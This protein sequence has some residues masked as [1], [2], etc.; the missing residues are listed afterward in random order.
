[1]LCVDVVAMGKESVCV[2][3]GHICCDDR[4]HQMVC[5]YVLSDLVS[6]CCGGLAVVLGW[7]WW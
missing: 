4:L 7:V 2:M 3:L 5:V 1:M 6:S